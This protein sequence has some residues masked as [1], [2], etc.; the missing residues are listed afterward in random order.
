MSLALESADAEE[1]S[2]EDELLDLRGAFVQG[3]ADGVAEE[4]FDGVLAEVADAAVERDRAC[5]RP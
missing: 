1:L 3:E 4:A 5:G 2:A